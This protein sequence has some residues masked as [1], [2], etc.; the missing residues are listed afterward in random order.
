MSGR[1]YFARA[2]FLL[3]ASRPR[4]RRRRPCSRAGAQ[5]LGHGAGVGRAPHGDRGSVRR[6]LFGD[7]AG[8][9]GG[10]VPAR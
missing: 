6:G 3:P 7:G 4:P 5:E 2:R 9:R 10:S 1:V 8:P